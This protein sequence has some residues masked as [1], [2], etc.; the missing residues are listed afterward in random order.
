[1]I[2][3]EYALHGTTSTKNYYEE[4]S[5]LPSWCCNMHERQW[6]IGSSIAK[7]HILPTWYR[8]LLPNTTLLCFVW[9]LIIPTWLHMISGF[10]SSRKWKRPDCKPKKTLCRMRRTSWTPSQKRCSSAASKSGRITGRSTWKN[11][12]IIWKEISVI[13]VYLNTSIFYE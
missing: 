5:A 9:I 3:H 13:L 10:S 8:A 4:N 1:M 6:A 7:T 11:K 2:H 12:R